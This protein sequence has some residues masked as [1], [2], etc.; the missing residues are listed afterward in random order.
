VIFPEDDP[1]SAEIYIG[2]Y[3]HTYIYIHTHTHTH[4][5][6]HIHACRGYISMS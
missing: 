1:L 6:T 5:D 3:V 2:T 4:T